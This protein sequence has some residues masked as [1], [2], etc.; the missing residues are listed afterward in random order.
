MDN[1]AYEHI[2]HPDEERDRNHNPSDAETYSLLTSYP[3]EADYYAL[4]GLARDPPPSD[5][6]IR[7]AYR[8]LTLSFHPDKQPA[9]LQEAAKRQFA[10]IQDAY[11][12]L[13]DPK[14]RVVYDALGAEGVRREWGKGGAMGQGGEAEEQRKQVG[15]SA[16][17]P[18]EFR[19]WFFQTMKQRERAV[20]EEMVRSKVGLSLLCI[21]RAG[22]GAWRWMALCAVGLSEVWFW[23][24]A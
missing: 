18:E 13:I 24:N 16:M 7:S 11:E 19:R 4:L 5:A 10:Q 6:S 12:T 3:T 14:K 15:V 1:S 23:T 21:S 17:K 2:P 22:G 9:E 8:T 20:V